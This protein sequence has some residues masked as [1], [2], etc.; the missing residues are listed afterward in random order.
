MRF[1]N[2]SSVLLF[3]V[4]IGLIGCS[5]SDTTDPTPAP[6]P[7]P[8]PDYSICRYTLNYRLSYPLLDKTKPTTITYLDADQKVK[9]ATLA[10][11]SFSFNVNYK[12]GDSVYVKINPNMYFLNKPVV[13][14]RSTYN[15]VAMTRTLA[16][17]T[18]SECSGFGRGV[19]NT[20]NL[21]FQYDSLPAPKSILSALGVSPTRIK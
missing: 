13:T 6:T 8:T 20:Q 5:Q 9:T 3:A 1:H 7:A 14:D 15:R 2:Y 17:T 19:T 16:S 21:I 11:T 10:D 4:L 18:N 12:Y